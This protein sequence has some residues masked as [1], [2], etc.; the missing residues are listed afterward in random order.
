MILVATSTFSI[1]IIALLGDS[2]LELT[3]KNL[4]RALVDSFTH[5]LVGSFSCRL[6]NLVKT[7]LFCIVHP[8]CWLLVLYLIYI[9]RWL[10]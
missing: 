2:V 1:C 5:G 10:V 7:D 9:P 4:H 3:D 8:Y 6:F